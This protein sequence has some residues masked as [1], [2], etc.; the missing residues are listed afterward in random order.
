[1]IKYSESELKLILSHYLFKNCGLPTFT[2]RLKKNLEKDYT[3]TEILYIES[4][5]SVIDPANNKDKA[6]IDKQYID[7][8][9]KYSSSEAR[10]DLKEYYQ[11]FNNG[12][13]HFYKRRKDNFTFV[14]DS[15]A[16]YLS[17]IDSPVEVPESDIINGERIYKR[18]KI[19]A[20]NALNAANYSCEG[21]CKNILF[22]KRNTEHFYTEAHHLIPLKFQD[23]FNNSLDVEANIISLCPMCH[24]LLHYGQDNSNLL[25][26]LFLQRVKRL[27]KCGIEITFEKLLSFY[28]GEIY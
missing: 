11:Q 6:N 3:E 19:V 4:I 13:L 15:S 23:R 28:E 12:L 25:E 2:Q 7:F 8:W 27:K 26:S 5:L 10:K 18:N 1:M 17:S 22:L 20:L 24:R 16:E 14:T 21:Q 9:N